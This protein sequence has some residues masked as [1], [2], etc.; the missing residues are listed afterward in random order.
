MG[1]EEAWTLRQ[2]LVDELKR[3]GRIRSSA[4]AAA[5]VRVPRELFVPGVPLEE[6]YRPSDAIVVKRLDGVGVSSASAPDVIAVMLEQLD[7]QPGQRVLEIGAGTGYNAALLAELV[8]PTGT[9][10]TIEIDEDLVLAAR[11]H[12]AVAGYPQV[13]VVVGDGALGYPA[14]GPFE[15]IILTV[16]A[17]DIAPAWRE[18]LH[19]PNGRLVLPLSIRGPQR[20]LAFEA[21]G[22]HLVTRSVSNCSFIQLRG[23]L[24]GAARR[25]PIGP[26]GEVVIGMSERAQTPS[27]QEIYA[28]LRGPAR[29][30]PSGVAANPGEV[31]NGLVIWL[32]GHEPGV[33]SVWS[34]AGAGEAHGVPELFGMPGKWRAS[35]GLLD[36]SGV[37]LL[38]WST[39]P[40][41]LPGQRELVVRVTEHADALAEHLIDRLQTWD[42]S[43]RPTDSALTIRAYPRQ[44]TQPRGEAVIRQQ[45]TDFVLEW[46]QLT[47]S[48]WA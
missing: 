21:A 25:V 43:G 47:P 42:T 10:V 12:L 28:W 14:A 16:A 18:Q 8:G 30:R 15:R 44:D 20:C 31:A 11:E 46:A 13:R 1:Q 9:V 39:E 37:A 38:A 48:G 45:W 22:D 5:M 27:D 35:L 7:V 32:A 40:P 23:A 3:E 17:R 26:A 36:A 2:V 24:A 19:E 33:C 4:I 34:D 41:S 6:V 29:T